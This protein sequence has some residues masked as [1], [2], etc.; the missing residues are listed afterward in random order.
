MRNMGMIDKTIRFICALSLAILYLINVISGIAALILLII[1]LFLLITSVVGICPIY[2][3]L[4]I[5]TK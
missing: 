5:N 1:A 2:K 3:P 4:S